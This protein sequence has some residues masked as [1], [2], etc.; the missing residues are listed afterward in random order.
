[1]FSSAF[2]TVDT[3]HAPAHAT[4]WF[5]KIIQIIIIKCNSLTQ[6]NVFQ[7]GPGAICG[8]FPPSLEKSGGKNKGILLDTCV[9]VIERKWAAFKNPVDQQRNP[10][11]FQNETP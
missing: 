2:V 5:D 6:V 10:V 1:M 11:M 3:P 8:I 4:I 7:V 9:D